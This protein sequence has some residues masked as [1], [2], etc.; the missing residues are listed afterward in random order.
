MSDEH[1][2]IY[3]P[4]GREIA[5]IARDGSGATRLV[6][7]PGISL[8]TRKQVQ[9][10]LFEAGN[11]KDPE[12]EGRL[13]TAYEA[14]GFVFESD[15]QIGQRFAK[16]IDFIHE[17]N[18]IEGIGEIDKKLVGE[19]YRKQNKLGC[20]GAWLLAEDRAKERKPLSGEDVIKMQRMLTDEQ[21]TYGHPLDKR[22]RG[23]IRGEKDWVS[24][25]G[26]IV[27]P[28]HPEDYSNF[29][30]RLNSGLQ[31]LKPKS[32]DDVLRYSAKMHLEYEI[33]HPFADG[34]GRTGRNVANYVLKYFDL[35]VLVFTNNDKEKY[36]DGFD[37]ATHEESSTM[38][39]YFI[40]KYREQ[41]PGFFK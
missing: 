25:G 18:L 13:K 17:S 30:A 15:E 20:V 1:M 5:N 41:N 2:K 24:V 3:D 32:V 28:P 8:D 12:F 31:L 27:P 6:L 37:V 38:E 34:N 39:A 9:D 14:K 16:N 19:H 22:H 7:V 26:R 23:V 21:V 4:E 33:M 11:T 36:Y 29:F 40:A 10:T 35:P